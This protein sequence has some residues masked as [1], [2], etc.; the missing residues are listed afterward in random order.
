MAPSERLLTVVAMT[1]A[2]RTTDRYLSV[3]ELAKRCPIGE[4]K[5]RA[6]LR[7]SDFPSAFVT[8]WDKN[9]RPRS[10]G[11]LLSEI[12]DYE[13][14]HRVH[15]SELELDELFSDELE[16]EIDRSQ[17]EESSAQAALP[18]AKKNMPRW[19]AA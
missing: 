4:T 13:N 12:V 19:K 10:I 3:P 9:G 6:L 14:A 17:S 18:P 8:L 1:A 7:T 11:F 16:D 2:T 15:M 5:I